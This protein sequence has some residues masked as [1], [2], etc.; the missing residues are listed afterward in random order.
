MAIVIT[1]N[2]KLPASGGMHAR[3]LYIG[4]IGEATREVF[5]VGAGCRLVLLPR[6]LLHVM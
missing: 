2:K 1:M 5:G 6:R 3:I 4:W